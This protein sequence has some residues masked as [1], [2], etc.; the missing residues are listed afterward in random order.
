MTL[1]RHILFQKLQTLTTGPY[2]GSG[3]LSGD[4]LVTMGEPVI[5]STELQ[6][7]GY[8]YEW[9]I[10]FANGSQTGYTDSPNGNVNTVTFNRVGI[11][12]VYCNVYRGYTLVGS[13]WKEVIVE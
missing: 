13:D 11:F 3:L 12:E 1:A 2:G 9:Y 6:G 10:E 8:S 5:F 4:D 7:I